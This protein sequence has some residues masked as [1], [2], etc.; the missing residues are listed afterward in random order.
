MRAYGSRPKAPT[1]RDT[2]APASV[3]PLSVARIVE[4]NSAVGNRA[5]ARMVAAR[6]VLQGQI[7]NGGAGLAGQQVKRTDD[8][9]LFTI[10]SA[11]QRPNGMIYRL[12]PADVEDRRKVPFHVWGANPRYSLVAPPTSSGPP[13]TTSLGSSSSTDVLDPPIPQLVPNAPPL[14]PVIGKVPPAPPLAPGKAAA[15]ALSAP[16]E[17]PAVTRLLGL[18]IQDPGRH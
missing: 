12:A 3:C 18:G 13:A 1:A 14:A 11:V 7:G 15:S 4:L 2:A 17:S 10:Q 6:R 5:I 8:G 9:A 16:K